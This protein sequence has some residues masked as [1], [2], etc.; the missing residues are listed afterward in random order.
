MAPSGPL[1]IV[2]DYIAGGTEHG[3]LL[4]NG[5]FTTI[6]FP[7][8]L[9]TQAFAVNANGIIVGDYAVTNANGNGNSQ[10]GYVLAAGTF[11]SIDFPGAAYTTAKG[12]NSQGDIVGIYYTSVGNANTQYLPTGNTG[13]GFLLS[14]GTYTSI[15][16]PGAILTEV[17]RIT[18]GGQILGRYQSPVD[19]KYHL[20]LFN[21]GVFSSIP[22]VPGSIETAPAD[23]S[24]GAL[25]G[26]G[27]IVGDYSNQTPIMHK[28]K[29]GKDLHGFLLSGGVYTTIDFPG[30]VATGAWGIHSSGVIVG[31]YLDANN[32]AHAY[33]RTP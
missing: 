32:R 31:A 5:A 29:F 12:I 23:I 13:H 18:D 24:F 20:F 27:D 4:S 1:L 15:D 11:T 33:I 21:D 6:D 19:G 16:F 7:G 17:W 2:G 3:Y 30:A 26:A 14:G 25:D 22:D 8:S 28:I 10:H 9:L